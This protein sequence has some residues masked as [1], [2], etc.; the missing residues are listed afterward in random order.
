MAGT[1]SAGHLQQHRMHTEHEVVHHGIT[2]MQHR[3]G[4]SSSS[5]EDDGEGGRRKKKGLK[6]KVKEKLPGGHSHGDHADQNAIHPH[7][8][9][10][11][12]GLME[13]IKEKLPGGHTHRDDGPAPHP[14]G[15]YQHDHEN[16][17]LMDKIKEKLPGHHH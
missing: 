2:P 15:A 12:K 17:G 8:D 5:S 10:E 11:D 13:K 1:G 14:H 7:G 4:N 6:E 3:S 16:K 9:H